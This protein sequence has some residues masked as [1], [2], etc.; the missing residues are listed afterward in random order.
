MLNRIKRQAIESGIP[1]T[2][3]EALQLNEIYS[4]DELCDA[5][6]EVRLKWSGNS[7]HTC[8]IVNARSGRC[9]EDC[10][11]C[12]QSAHH[13]TGISEYE[14]IP[15][16]EMMQAFHAN[17]DRGVKCFSLVTSG[18]KVMPSHMAYF[19]NLY[20][21][22]NA[23]GGIN[24]CASMGLLD[25]E[26]LQQLWDS[27]VRKYHCNLETSPSYFPK[28]C[29]THT[30][31]DKLAT[32]KMA[33]EIGF[34]ICSGGIIGMGES[35]RDRLELAEAARL[36]GASSI[37][38]NILQ[39][40]KGTALEGID[41]IPEEE[42]TRSVALMRLVAP[43]CTLHFAGGRARLSQKTVARILRGGIN[44][45]LVGDMLTT[46]GNKIDADYSLFS[47]VGYEN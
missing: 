45:A 18:R 27:G 47:E 10:K 20:K 31:E 12:A 2:V 39:P 38:I 8:S 14:H 19:C 15:H 46:I 17:R 1:A 25:R 37:P 3:E 13:K 4:T 6:D 9:G 24:L 28:L 5:A 44:G 21:E 23:E 42:I 11:W 33:R 22:A 43:K 16:D 35:M 29:S 40:I 41:L 26:Q 32:I 7:V 36:A 34:K 30:Y